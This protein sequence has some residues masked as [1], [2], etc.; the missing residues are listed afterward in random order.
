MSKHQFSKII[1]GSIT[2]LLSLLYVKYDWSFW[3]II[4]TLVLW[5]SI[6]V[7]GSFTIGFNYH[8]TSI[9]KIKTQKKIIAITFDDGPSAYTPTILEVLKNNNAKASFFCV[10]KN[11][12]DKPEI[13]ANIIEDG[14]IIGNHTFSHSRDFGFKSSKTILQE[15]EKTNEI[16]LKLTGSLPKYFRPPFGVTNPNVSKA[17]EK[18]TLQLIGWNIRSF[19]T[20]TESETKIYNRIIRQI[21]PGSIILLHDTSEKTANVLAQL[22]T[23]LNKKKYIC[24]TIDELIKNKI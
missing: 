1:F 16:I 13:V 14:H 20:V 24:V 8:I 3:Y 23:Y 19:D 17:I 11:I 21:K 2:I 10:G 6:I 4:F 5:I 9:S 22:L 15:I 12:L 18:S 7:Y